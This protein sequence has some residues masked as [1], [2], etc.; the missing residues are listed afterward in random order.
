MFKIIKNTDS[1]GSLAAGENWRKNGARHPQ[2]K[3]PPHK[4]VIGVYL[5]QTGDSLRLKDANFPPLVPDTLLTPSSQPHF[6]L[7]DQAQV[8][9]TPALPVVHLTRGGPRL[10]VYTGVEG[11]R[12]ANYSTA[13][14]VFDNKL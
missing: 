7:K 2:L 11:G 10:R 13:E 9:L 8:W 5:M 1:T 6:R 12:S 3:Y 4:P 14:I